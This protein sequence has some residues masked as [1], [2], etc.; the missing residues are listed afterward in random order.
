[1]TEV[2]KSCRRRP[3]ES[4]TVCVNDI[5]FKIK[6]NII[7]ILTTEIKNS[8]TKKIKIKIVDDG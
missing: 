4:R 1:M 5:K 7:I 2:N 8:S 3:H 6:Y